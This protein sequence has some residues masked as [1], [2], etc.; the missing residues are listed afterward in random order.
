MEAGK[1]LQWWPAVPKSDTY[2]DVESLAH[3]DCKELQS[4][5]EDGSISIPDTIIG[6]YQGHSLIGMI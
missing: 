5:I 3:V 2:V 1:L 6:W 4:G